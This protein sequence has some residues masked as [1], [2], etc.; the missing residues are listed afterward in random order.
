[1]KIVLFIC[2]ML[3][4]LV[5]V[6]AATLALGWSVWSVVAICGAVLVSGQLLYFGVILGDAWLRRAKGSEDNRP[7]SSRKHGTR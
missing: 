1:M 4:A 6:A 5:T 7:A 3:C 2:G